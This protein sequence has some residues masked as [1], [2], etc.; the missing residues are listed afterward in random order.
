MLFLKSHRYNLHNTTVI[1]SISETS[2]TK[3]MAISKLQRIDLLTHNL[4]GISLELLTDACIQRDGFPGENFP[5]HGDPPCFNL[6]P[7]L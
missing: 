7:L 1:A 6:T 3:V 4:C 2:H 5:I